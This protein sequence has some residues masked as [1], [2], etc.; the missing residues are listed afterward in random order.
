MPQ[1][2]PPLRGLRMGKAGELSGSA[3][4]TARV[5]TRKMGRRRVQVDWRRMV[6]V[7]NRSMDGFVDVGYDYCG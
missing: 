4:G 3:T 6:L 2:F 1:A 5:V 7:V